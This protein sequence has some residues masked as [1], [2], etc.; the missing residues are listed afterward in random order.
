MPATAMLSSKLQTTLAIAAVELRVQLRRPVVWIG[1]ALVAGLNLAEIFPNPANLQRLSGLG[2][3]A[4]AAARLFYLSMPLL[5]LLAALLAAG[6]LPAERQTGM[7]A[8]LWTTPAA[9]L[10][11]Y[12]GGKFLGNFLA[13]GLLLAGLAVLG[14]LERILFLPQAAGLQGLLPFAQALLLAGLVP[15]AYILALALA[16]GA[17]LKPRG[18][19]LALAAYLLWSANFWSANQQGV[20]EIFRFGGNFTHLIY[21]I[22]SWPH[23]AAQIAAGWQALLFELGMTGAVLL[24]L[25]ALIAWQPREVR[26]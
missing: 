10:L 5:G 9:G 14:G 17:L 2:S 26:L 20:T 21:L 6:R 4:Y 25:V 1:F 15:L 19:S 16:G 18:A 23:H 24:L 7:A 3:S 22:P 11:T 8:L 13:F 12:V